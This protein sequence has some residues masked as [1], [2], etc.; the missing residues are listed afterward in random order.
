MACLVSGRCCPP[1]SGHGQRPDASVET[2]I[3]IAELTDGLVVSSRVSCRAGKGCGAWCWNR[4]RRCA[5]R[6]SRSPRG[7]TPSAP[8]TPSV[9]GTRSGSTICST[10]GEPAIISSFIAASGLA[11]STHSLKKWQPN[12]AAPFW[13]L[14]V[15][16]YITLGF[17]GS[18]SLR[19]QAH[20][21]AAH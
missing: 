13:A 18:T 16:G 10:S 20:F 5:R 2:C 9:L 19:E 17:H 3:P 11:S 4:R 1:G 6:G 12:C 14:L 15:L 21:L 8:S 7:P